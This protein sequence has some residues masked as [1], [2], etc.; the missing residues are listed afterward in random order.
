MMR[1][2]FALGLEVT[3]GGYLGAVVGLIIVHLIMGEDDE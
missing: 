2:V 1:S 3:L